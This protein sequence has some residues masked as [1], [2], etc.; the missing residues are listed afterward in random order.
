[1]EIE[2]DFGKCLPASTTKK[3]MEKEK[4][5]VQKWKSAETRKMGNKVLPYR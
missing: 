4:Q 1:M 5:K 2:K 3:S